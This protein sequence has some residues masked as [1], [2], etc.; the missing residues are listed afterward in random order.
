MEKDERALG[1]KVKLYEQTDIPMKEMNELGH[2]LH[3]DDA[4]T[5]SRDTKYSK[6][7]IARL[8]GMAKTLE[9]TCCVALPALFLL[10]N[11]I[12]WPWLLYFADSFDD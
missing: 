10:F 3:D 4:T 11:C 1:E 9:S 8:V 2:S 6:E 12:Y 7:K 5:T